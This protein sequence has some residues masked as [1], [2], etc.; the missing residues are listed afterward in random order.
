MPWLALITLALDGWGGEQL[1]S[2]PGDDPPLEDLRPAEASGAPSSLQSAGGGAPTLESVGGGL[3]PVVQGGSLT[4]LQFEAA[5]GARWSA[6]LACQTEHLAGEPVE[7][8]LNV[9]VEPD[10]AVSGAWVDGDVPEPMQ[11]CVIDAAKQLR[12]PAPG[13]ETGVQAPIWLA[14]RVVPAG[15]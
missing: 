14:E 5:L 2:D 6:L 11:D 9:V 3:E 1:P 8:V 13:A 10:G 4:S 12:L 15:T 7:L